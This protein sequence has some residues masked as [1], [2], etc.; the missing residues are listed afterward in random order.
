[1]RK[2]WLTALILGICALSLVVQPAFAAPNAAGKPLSIWDNLSGVLLQ[3]LAVVLV[4]ELALAALFQ[5][6]LYQM[7]LNARALKTPVMFVVGLL[8]VLLAKYDPMNDILKLEVGAAATDDGARKILTAV[9]SAMI[10][11]AAA[12]AY[13][14]C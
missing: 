3:L 9:L 10:I 6:R 1:M 8:I 5:W 13:S 12:P 7:A 11:A 2:S 4:V 14:R